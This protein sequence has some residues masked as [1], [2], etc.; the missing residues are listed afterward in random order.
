MTLSN[1]TS[2]ESQPEGTIVG[3][4]SVE[5]YE[6]NKNLQYSLTSGKGSKSNDLF[7]L[8][9]YNNLRAKQS[10]DFE[11]DDRNMS[12]RVLAKGEGN[13]S[14]EKKFSI[15]LLDL[16]SDDH[17][18]SKP[19]YDDWNSTHDQNGTKPPM[20]DHNKTGD[21]NGT[22]NNPKDA[23]Y[24][25]PL[26]RTVD[27]SLS[28]DERYHFTGKVLADGGG[29]ILEVGIEISNNL[30]FR[31]SQLVAVELK[32]NRIKLVLNELEP[33]TR[34][35][36]RAYARNDLGVGKGTIKR[37]RTPSVPSPKTFWS[38]LEDI[39]DGWMSS[40]WFGSFLLQENQWAYHQRLGWIYLPV[41]QQNG[42]W[43]WRDKGEWLWTS[44]ES[45]PYLWKNKS[46]SWLYLLP[47]V[48]KKP[49]FYDFE[50]SEFRKL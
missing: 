5:G 37:L 25:L 3:K 35:Y 41:E 13:A 10:F 46:G 19:P 33:D 14:I 8:G 32:E 36:F 24:G 20:D 6:Q 4:I 29:E 28:K 1:H 42:I 34:Y 27:V 50:R 18:G 44:K 31:K 12:V 47:D 38:R 39:G 23:P 43:L 15:F 17:N 16:S 30:F 9:P 26:V 22:I 48:G 45:W 21:Q 7:F 40:S 2:L 11:K 49:I